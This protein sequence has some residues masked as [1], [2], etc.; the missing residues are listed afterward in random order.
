MTAIIVFEA[1]RLLRKYPN[2]NAFYAA[3]DAHY[4]EDVNIGFAVDAGRG[5]KVPVIHHAD[6]KGIIEITTEMRERVVAYLEDE[7]PVKALTLCTFTVTD[8][9]GEGVATFHPLINQ[10]QSAI[11]GI[12]AEVFAPG[13]REGTF[14][15]VLSFDHQLSEGEL[16]HNS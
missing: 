2:F 15:L 1:A 8:L 12:C 5:L 16:P 9:S 7:L 3:G 11:L 13:S 10:G 4:Y 14:N 6:R